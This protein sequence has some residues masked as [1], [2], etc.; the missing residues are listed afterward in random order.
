MVPFERAQHL[1]QVSEVADAVGEPAG[2]QAD[3][4]EGRLHGV[5]V[6]QEQAV[7][8]PV[9]QLLDFGLLALSEGASTCRVVLSQESRARLGS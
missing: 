3:P 7:C 8:E 4:L 6:V 2:D 5:E 1:S 9:A